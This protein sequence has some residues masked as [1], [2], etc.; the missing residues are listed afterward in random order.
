MGDGDA[1]SSKKT[2]KNLSDAIDPSSP[3]YLH[4]LDFPKQLHVNEVL[5]DGNYMDWAQEMSNFLYAKNKI[6]FVDGTIKKPEIAMEKTIRDSVKYVGTAPEMWSDLQER[7]G[8][9]NAPR[10]Y[11]LE[12]KIVA[13]R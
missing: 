12:Q 2:N 9:E 6:D 4:P 10:A 11:E 7:F 1:E 3:Y 5:T 8:K 13:T